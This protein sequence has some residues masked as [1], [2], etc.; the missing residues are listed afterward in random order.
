MFQRAVF[1]LVLYVQVFSAG[2]TVPLR[3]VLLLTFSLCLE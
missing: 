1:R 2:G 3:F